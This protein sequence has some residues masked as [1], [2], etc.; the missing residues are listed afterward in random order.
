VCNHLRAALSTI[1]L[2][3][4]GPFISGCGQDAPHDAPENGTLRIVSLAPSATEIL[5]ALQAGDSL[6]GATDYCDYPPEAAQVQRVGGFGAPNL[7][8]LLALRPDLVVAAGFEREELI[9]V[10]RRSGIRVLDVRIRNCEETF[11][12]IRQIGEAVDK[13]RQAESLVARM[14]ADLDAVAAQNAARRRRPKVFVEIAAQPLITAGAASFLDD[15]IERAGGVNVAHEIAREY[16]NVSAEKVIEW[17]PDV[18]V[19]AKMGGPGDAAAQLSQRIG[20]ADIAAVR[21]GAII[22]DIPPDL[23]FRPGPRLIE[24]VKAIAARLHKESRP[25]K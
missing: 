6:V 2:L 4:A 16:P 10:L 3:A 21:K 22:D 25:D 9:G 8:S 15:L 14:R 17:N 13:R 24:G 11:D 20:W 5:F 18:I 7:E 23:L 1:C 19:V 12:S